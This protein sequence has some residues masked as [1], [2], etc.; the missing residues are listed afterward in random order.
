MC[1]CVCVCVCVRF[2][3]AI[4]QLIPQ[5]SAIPTEKFVLFL[6]KGDDNTKLMI[7]SHSCSVEYCSRECQKNDFMQNI[8]K[9]VRN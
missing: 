4:P 5:Q 8:R 2:V 7:C 3:K 9:S 1:V 6:G